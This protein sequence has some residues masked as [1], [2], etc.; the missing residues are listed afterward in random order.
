MI[1]GIVSAAVIGLLCAQVLA[2]MQ[3][4]QAPQ[5]L[6]SGDHISTVGSGWLESAI[7]TRCTP[8]YFAS[9]T[10]PACASLANRWQ[11]ALPRPGGIWIFG[12]VSRICG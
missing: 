8:L 7:T 9:P 1:R 3:S 10:C 4:R 5:R 12:L 6:L 11:E 2:W